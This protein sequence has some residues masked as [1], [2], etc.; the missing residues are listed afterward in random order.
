VSSLLSLL[1]PLLGELVDFWRESPTRSLEAGY[2]P[3]ND[4][5]HAGANLSVKRA[6]IAIEKQSGRLA[7]Y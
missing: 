6:K 3:V 7:R 5:I 2:E 4:A 1:G